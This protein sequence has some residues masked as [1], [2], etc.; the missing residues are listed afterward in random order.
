MTAE[1]HVLEAAEC[2]RVAGGAVFV[3][4]LAPI[5]S[6]RPPPLPWRDIVVKPQPVPWLPIGGG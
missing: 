5:G 1:L 2:E 3:V 6:I 4:D